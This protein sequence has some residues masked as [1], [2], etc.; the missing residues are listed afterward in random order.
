[1]SRGKTEYSD[2]ISSV[3]AIIADARLGRMFSLVDHEDREHE[4]DLVIPAQ[5]CDA[6]A[7]NLMATHGASLWA[8]GAQILSKLGLTA[9]T[10]VSN[11]KAPR[12]VG[13]EAFGLTI[14]GT[15]AMTE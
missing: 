15:R 2:A 12:V 14:T 6:A 10:L 8:V 4:G 13:L 3:E 1:M 9:I 7:V 11:S 5:V